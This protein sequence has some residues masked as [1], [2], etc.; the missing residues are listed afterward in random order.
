MSNKTTDVL[1][2]HDNKISDILLKHNMNEP[3]KVIITKGAKFD[4]FV[5][6]QDKKLQEAINKKL[7]NI[8]DEYRWHVVEGI[9]SGVIDKAVKENFGTWEKF[10]ESQNKS[11]RH[12]K[13]ILKYTRK[14]MQTIH[15]LKLKEED[16]KELLKTCFKTY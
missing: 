10:N 3:A 16:L 5:E 8:S 9:V 2:E 15:E 14:I 4:V 11:C 7:K 6:I 13:S 1:L 12:K